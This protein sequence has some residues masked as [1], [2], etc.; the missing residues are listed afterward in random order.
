MKERLRAVEG[1]RNVTVNPA[2]ASVTIEHDRNID[3]LEGW[4]PAMQ[5]A[6]ESAGNPCTF[7]GAGASN[8]CVGVEIDLISLMTKLLPMVLPKHPI[9]Q[10]AELV[11]EPVLRAVL[12]SS[13][14]R[15]AHEALFLPHPAASE[16][17]VPQG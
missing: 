11:A 8:S 10:V 1:I 12:G 9:V 17:A 15:P 3:P 14:K 5:G 6:P 13:S 4:A 2:A 7:R 16:A